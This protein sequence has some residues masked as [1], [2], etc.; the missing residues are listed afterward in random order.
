MK[1]EP[2]TPSA[3]GI[4]ESGI[5]ETRPHAKSER[6]TIAVLLDSPN[7]FGGGYEAQLRDALDRKCCEL[8]YDLLLIYGAALEGPRPGDTADNAI[9]RLLNPDICDGVIVASALLAAYCE[10]E[11]VA[12]L[13][14]R[15]RPTPLCSIGIAFPGIPSVILDNRT[16]MVAAVE[17]LIRDHG[18]RR[19]V[20]LGGPPKN[21]EAQARFEAYRDTL[22]RYGL[23]LDPTLVGCGNFRPALGRA[24]MEELLARGV[25]LDAVVAA[26][27]EMAV[28]AIEALRKAGRRVPQDIPV[29]GFDDLLLARQGNPPL[30][31]VA[32]PYVLMVNLA[33]QNIVDQ[34]EG[35]AVP[36]CTEV[37]SRFVC[38]QSCGCGYQRP[39]PG[40]DLPLATA[41]GS[42]R[43]NP[44][45][46]AELGPTLAAILRGGAHDGVSAA[47]RLL[48]GLTA[49]IAGEKDA[50]QGAVAGLLA[51]IGGN[52]EQYW[53][54]QAA[55]TC[56]R[57]A[58]GGSCGARIDRV[59][60]DGLI[61]T[62]LSHTTMQMQHRLALDDNYQRLL[63]VAEH[64]SVALDRS[65]LK[66]A[67]LEDLP[68]AGV[69]T[70]FLSCTSDGGSTELE[71]T[72]CL[73]DGVAV[74]PAA[75]RFPSSQLLPPGVLLPERRYTLLVMPLAFESQLLG[76]VAFDY[77]DGINAYA[78]FRNEIT[79]VLKSIRLHQELVQETMLHERSIQERLAATK[80]MEALS[81]LAGG[82]AHDLNNALGPLVTL[83]E[84]ILDELGKLPVAED[85]I[86]ELR[87]DVESIKHA[88]L[89]AAQTIKDLLTL[90]RQ[91]RT[92]KES[93]DLNLVVKSCL[94][95]S[96]LRFASE[97]HLHVNMVVDFATEPLT[98][99]GSESQLA[100]A[101]G[102]LVRNAVEAVGGKGEVVLHTGRQHLT[103]P[104]GSFETVPPGYYAVLSVADDGC[105]MAAYELGHVFEP[106]FTTKRA[107]ERSGSGLGLAIVHGV[108][109][110][111]GGFIDVASLPDTGTTFTLYLPLVEA[112]QARREEIAAAPHGNARILIVDDDP[113][114]LRTCRRVLIR[115]GYQVEI[116]QSG[117]RAYE[118]FNRAATAG[119]SP[120]DL[121]IM[122]V[123]LGEMLDGLQVFEL[124]QRLFPAQKAILVSGHAP[125]ERAEVAVK[126]G[127]TWLAK[128][129]SIDSLA[130]IVERVLHAGATP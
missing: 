18:R 33:I 64:A 110:E 9:F 83:P 79:A 34:V 91:G 48:E 23:A 51:N 43:R 92:V 95:D 112:E 108:V 29:V 16:G 129:Y 4:L 58:L 30:T 5:S 100:R 107:G 69:R 117:L 109:K 71:A 116:I 115:L 126:K 89:R 70:A 119:T 66:A 25:E 78:A 39:R 96:S 44:E 85:A 38:R 26:N 57:D 24:A 12:R 97:G 63:T 104:A 36:A 32:Q 47:S 88:S 125:N 123:V 10:P 114:Q 80:R 118:L 76:V 1:T 75:P 20:F 21:P 60:Y 49:E 3:P 81:V 27:D 130:R 59:L 45:P 54:L 90:G 105:G 41:T 37:P 53:A 87:A 11:Q 103:A 28:G 52:I 98:V 42:A 65:S 77:A 6:L 40:G 17:H 15:Y 82:V 121:I 94:A 31:T 101:V 14:E 113:M 72:V 74:E 99:R 124:V 67:L 50:F 46:L 93:L 120:F 13:A 7:A 55:M 68:A 35:R 62:A 73:R 2:S 8:G 128:P 22:A 61:Q 84:V 19:P 86:R 56:L 111:H 122:D 102:N 127:L 106:F